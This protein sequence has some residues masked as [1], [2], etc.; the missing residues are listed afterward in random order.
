VQEHGGKPIKSIGEKGQKTGFVHRPAEKIE[1]YLGRIPKEKKY[2]TPFV[3]LEAFPS[4][5]ARWRF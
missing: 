2:S 1:N 5:L 4:R 3:I